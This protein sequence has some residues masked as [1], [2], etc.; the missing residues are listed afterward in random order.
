M[1]SSETPVL[2]E[3]DD[4]VS[5]DFT[6]YARRRRPLV[7]AFERFAVV[8]AVPL[9]AVED[10][11]VLEVAAGSSSERR[12]EFTMLYTATAHATSAIGTSQRAGLRRRRMRAAG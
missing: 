11:A 5:P 3:I 4:S 1:R 2:I 8:P 12:F 9:P 6:T 7:F 10:R